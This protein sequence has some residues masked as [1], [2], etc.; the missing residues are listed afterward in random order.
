MRVTTRHNEAPL[1]IAEEAKMEAKRTQLY[2]NPFDS[3]L[4]FYDFKYRGYWVSSIDIANDHSYMVIDIV[5][6]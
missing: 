4:W 5:K 3:N 6:A 2:C 1:V